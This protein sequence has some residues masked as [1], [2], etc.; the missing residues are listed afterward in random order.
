M[1]NQP[2]PGG[3]HGHYGAQSDF[4]NDDSIDLRDLFFRLTRGLFQIFGFALLG[5]AIAAGISLLLSRVQ[6]TSTNTRVV[7]SFPGFERGEYPDH[8]KFQPDDLRAPTVIS[9]ALQRAGLDTSSDF[10]SKIRS[11]LSIE[12]IVPP[13]IVKERDRLRA[14]GQTPPAYV[15]DEYVVSLSLNPA[16]TF[17]NAQ[18]ERLLKE[19]VS[20]YRENFYRT[21]GQSPL[22][23]GTAFETLKTADLAEYELVFN[24]DI[25]NIRDYLQQQADRAKSFRSPTTNLSFRDLLEQTELFSQIQLNEV[26]AIVHQNGLSR[27]R[28][29]AILK[30]NYHLR[31]IEENEQKAL[32]EEKLVRDLLDQVQTRS[33]NY[34]LGVKS[35]ANQSRADAPVLDQGLIDSIVANDSYNFLVRRALDAGLNVKRIQ[36][37]KKRLIDQRDNMKSFLS[38]TPVDQSAIIAQATTALKNLESAYNTLITN[39]RKTHADF[40]QQEYS[41]AIRISNDV[42]TAGVL[43]PM[44]ISGLVGAFLGFALGA[45]LSLLGV[46]IGKPHRA[47]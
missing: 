4:N 26:L 3:E 40:S 34:V 30:M 2:S 28:A 22:A 17:S 23:F 27:N 45:G 8:S 25:D 46:Y 42:R 14:A 37:E 33:Q 16:A 38:E 12:G 24:S 11:A 39:I 9:E 36:A 20:V 43:R 6:P 7:F 47:A 21:Y 15:P 41:N 19:I 35:Q 18:R 44:A 31:L 10:Q 32:E 29:T 1:A 5:L 13:N